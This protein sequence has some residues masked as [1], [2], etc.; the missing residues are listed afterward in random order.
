MRCL[1]KYYFNMLL[2]SNNQHQPSAPYKNQTEAIHLD[3]EGV[4]TVVH[5]N[6]SDGR[7]RCLPQHTWPITTVHRQRYNILCKRLSENNYGSKCARAN[8]FWWSMHLM[9]GIAFFT[10]DFLL[11]YDGVKI[12]NRK[13][14]R[15]RNRNRNEGDIFISVNR[16]LHLPRPSL[17]FS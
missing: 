12:R 8:L 14:K 7:S 2:L 5:C 3:G 17:Q 16:T 10:M 15:N 4:S 6:L 1:L 11:L 9:H 13:R